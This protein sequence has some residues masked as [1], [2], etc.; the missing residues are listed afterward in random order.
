MVE[1]SASDVPVT[2]DF[3]V[4]NFAV[5]CRSYKARHSLPPRILCAG[6]RS[7]PVPAGVHPGGLRKASILEY[8]FMY[9]TNCLQS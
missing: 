8:I 7:N 5:P 9:V 2:D 3:A 4:I 6:R 1:N